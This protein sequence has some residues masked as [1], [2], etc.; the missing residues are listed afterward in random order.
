MA[1]DLAHV[2]ET[3][4]RG[5]RIDQPVPD[6][7]DRPT[8]TERRAA[9]D[10]FLRTLAEALRLAAADTL[11][12]NPRDL[13]ATVELLGAAPLVILSDSVPGGAGY[14]RRL[15]DD[16][17]FSAR[18]LLGSSNRGPG[19]PSWLSLRDELFAVPE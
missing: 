4:L 16:S 8:E 5:I 10:G 12:T 2:F 6:F 11:E 1:V 9:R 13:R 7:S 19:L 14:C 3:D 15:L 18:V 17:R